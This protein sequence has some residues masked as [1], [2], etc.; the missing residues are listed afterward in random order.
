MSIKSKMIAINA[1]IACIVLLLS[2]MAMMREWGKLQTLNSASEAQSVVSAMSK[3]TIEL[4]LERSLAQVAL[5]LDS[6]VSSDIR[7]MLD[8]QRKTS[9]ALFS[10][11][12]SVL[13]N[14]P[15]IEDRKEFATRLDTILSGIASLRDAVD[16]QIGNSID[17]RSEQDIV[18][19]PKKIKASVSK[20]NDL[21]FDIRTLMNQASSEILATDLVMQRAWAIREYGGR[22]R[23]LFA[24]AT[25]RKEPIAAADLAYMYENHGRAEQAWEAL[26]RDKNNALLSN[27]L[28]EGIKTVGSDYFQRYNALRHDLLASAHTG[29]YSVEFPVLFEQSESALQ[30]A[31][32]LMNLGIDSN[33]AN[34]EAALGDA[35][36]LFIEEAII[37]LVA[38]TFVG[39]AI[40]YSIRSIIVPIR[41][42]TNVAGILA[43]GDN[44]IAIPYGDR[45][46]EI[47]EM[48]K[49]VQVFKD[50]AIERERLESQAKQDNTSR[51]EREQHVNDLI[52]GFRSEVEE[53]LAAV[54]DNMSQM[55]STATHLSNIAERTSER[56]DNASNA[57]SEASTNVQNVASAS[58]ELGASIQQIAQQVNQTMS[59]VEKATSSA[60]TT[61]QQVAS[62]AE[63]AQKIGDVISLI[64]EIAEQTNLLALNATIEAARAGEAGKGFAV[65]AS[66]VKQLAEQTAKATS[67]IGNQISGIQS[68][69]NDAASA[70]KS[71]AEMVQEVNS[72]TATIATAV[73]EQDAATK[74]IGE[75]VQQAASGTADVSA[76]VQDVTAAI[77]ETR[78][79]GEEM[80]KVSSVTSERSQSLKAAVDR[81][82]SS[83]AAA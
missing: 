23:T 13:L 66:E 21:A 15:S 73:E 64:S 47:G 50:S 4:S 81:F 46:D 5:N 61:N 27:T 14:S 44:T 18:S 76:S 60:E 3:A 53:L 17:K 43:K 37:A 16:S 1:V 83:V 9:N 80:L 59:I 58:D 34:T 70:I 19:L 25:V 11:A 54:T 2:A 74:E 35:W 52:T 62:L 78:Q 42:M 24:I 67:D 68:S 69:T 7:G 82:L 41:E 8:N 29:D 51:L 55:N 28:R 40:F 45:S 49:A 39:F 63:A 10:D 77:V 75:N 30:T 12:K 22:E 33:I 79:V 65:V 31:I 57:S 32:A 6:P 71:I 38:L 36:F 72:N 48:A 20:L 56:A 26:R